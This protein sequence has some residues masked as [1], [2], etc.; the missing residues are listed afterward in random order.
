MVNG[1]YRL[2]YYSAEDIDQRRSY[3]PHVEDW[4]TFLT[5]MFVFCAN[6]SFYISVGKKRIHYDDFL[7]FY[8]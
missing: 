6:Y 7:S 2:V 1:F 4:M 3:V 5:H 8:I